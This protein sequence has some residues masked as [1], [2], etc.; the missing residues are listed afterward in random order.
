MDQGAPIVPGPLVRVVR[1]IGKSL[2]P[3]SK[4]IELGEIILVML[5]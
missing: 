2:Q 3:A 1:M 5:G 4:V